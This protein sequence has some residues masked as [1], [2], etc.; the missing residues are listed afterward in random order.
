[1]AGSNALLRQ[2]FAGAGQ[3]AA[4]DGDDGAAGLGQLDQ[5]G[6]AAAHPGDTGHLRGA[7]AVKLECDGVGQL[8][9]A[10]AA[11]A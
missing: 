1:M 2:A 11:G 8:G 9:R 10:A 4:V 6:D 5:R 7:V 3:G